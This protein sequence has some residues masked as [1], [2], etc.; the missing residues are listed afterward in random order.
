MIT[1]FFSNPALYTIKLGDH[2][3]NVN[4]GTEQ[5]IKAIKVISHPSYNNPRLSSDIA[6]I[7]LERPATLNSRVNTV[8]LPPQ[9]YVVPSGSNCYISG[10][11]N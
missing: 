2:N 10:T 4:E 8:C 3:R 5:E 11:V 1:S 9:D 6:L 7:Q